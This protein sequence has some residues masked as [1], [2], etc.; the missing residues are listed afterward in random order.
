M[1][2]KKTERER[3]QN[4]K[5]KLRESVKLTIPIGFLSKEQK[6]ILKMFSKHM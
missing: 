4:E 6:V 2:R 3:I 5:F 1:S